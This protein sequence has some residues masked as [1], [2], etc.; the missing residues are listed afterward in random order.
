MTV[1]IM[2]IPQGLARAMLAGLPPKAGRHASITL[3]ALCAL[4]G[5]SRVLA[6]GPVAVIALTTATAISERAGAGN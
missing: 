6:V 3:L 5:T 1:T 4:L 2:P